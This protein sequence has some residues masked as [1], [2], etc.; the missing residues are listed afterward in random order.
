MAALESAPADDTAMEA[1]GAALDEAAEL[2]G[3]HRDYSRQRQAVIAAHQELRERELVKMSTLAV[4]WPT[5]CVGAAYPN[6]TPAWPRRPASQ[7]SGWRSSAG[8]PSRATQTLAEL[9]RASLAQ[10]R[11]LTA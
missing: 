7:S 3:G 4:A 6:R 5:P 1:V 8:S 2:L 9:M 10:L 11:T